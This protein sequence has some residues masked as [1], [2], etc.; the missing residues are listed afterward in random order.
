MFKERELQESLGFDPFLWAVSWVGRYPGRD[1][2]GGVT[3]PRSSPC[4]ILPERVSV[5]TS[6]LVPANRES[7]N[8]GV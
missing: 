8:V 5:S 7:S 4:G 6:G 1:N 3:H 2:P